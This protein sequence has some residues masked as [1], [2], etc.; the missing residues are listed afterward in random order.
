L[1]DPGTQAFKVAEFLDQL[2]P[3]LDKTLT[4][5]PSI[6]D[7]KI[8]D[9][10]HLKSLLQPDYSDAAISSEGWDAQST[11]AEIGGMLEMSTPAVKKLIILSP[12]I[13]FTNST[14]SYAFWLKLGFL[15]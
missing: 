12:T 13:L 3:S 10:D 6:G 4:Q 11:R 8:A 15:S 7:L 1:D 14:F 9:L 5:K 2:L